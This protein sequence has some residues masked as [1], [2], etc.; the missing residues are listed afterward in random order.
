MPA[1]RISAAATLLV[2]GVFFYLRL[3]ASVCTGTQCD[4]YIWPSLA[5]PFAVVVLVGITGWYAVADAKKNDPAWV[6]PFIAATM[7]GVLGPVL[8]G[9]VFR[10]H[11]DIVVAV[12]TVLY[13]LTPLAA[14][15][16][17]FTKAPAPPA[18]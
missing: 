14:L 1:I 12:A 4:S 15:A 11:P 9:F 18:P 7:A 17:S 13:L 3:Q 10:D 5:V 16:Y 6:V 8:V 2:L